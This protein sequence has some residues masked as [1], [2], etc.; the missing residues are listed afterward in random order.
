VLSGLALVLA[1]CACK[2]REPDPA[3]TSESAPP[4]V[5]AAPSK[6]PPVR[7]NARQGFEVSTPNGV[8]HL[9]LVPD[10]TGYR[11][12]S[13]SGDAHGRIKVQGDRV[14][15]VGSAGSE[16]AKVKSKDYGFKVYGT[17]E[18]V[19]LKAKRRGSGYTF[20]RAD[21]SPLGRWEG[22]QGNLGGDKLEVIER[23][24]NRVILRGGKE[25]ASVSVAV[26]A[27]AAGLLALTELSF[28]QRLATLVFRLELVK[29]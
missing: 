9:R 21:D 3:A 17:G 26:P 27:D 16:Q 25:V 22:G 7:H 28:E 5:A 2:K 18:A 14:K 20:K 12:Q 8:Q 13:K 10:S 23:G 4:V 11:L 19:V 15:L 29:P 24:E 1:L 6:P